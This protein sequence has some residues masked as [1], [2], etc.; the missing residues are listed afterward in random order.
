M[1]T[2]AMPMAFKVALP[3][4]HWVVRVSSASRRDLT[5]AT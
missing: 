2:F 3:T 5:F 1:V 4:V